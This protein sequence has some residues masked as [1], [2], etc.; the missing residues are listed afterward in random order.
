MKVPKISVIMSV[1][2]GE[3]YL[4]ESVNSILN[5]TF[6]DFEFIIIND[7]S[8]DKTFE[9]LNKITDERVKIILNKKNKGLTASL[10]KCLK[11]ARGKYIARMDAD[12][13]SEPLRLEKEFNFLE[14]NREYGVVGTF[15]KIFN[16]NTGEYI[17]Q[18]KPVKNSEIKEFLK[19]DNCLAHG[20]V[21]IRKEALESSGHYDER[22]LQSQDY[23]LWFRISRNWKLANI[24]EYLYTWRDHCGNIS[25]EKKNE[26]MHY[27]E[28]AK[29]LAKIDEKENDKTK[30]LNPDFSILMAN[31]NNGKYI[32]ES[33]LSVI[34]QTFK[35]WE[36]VIVDDKS[37]DNSIEII[38]SYLKDKR[39]RL[40]KNKINSGYIQSLKKLVYSSRS[41]IFG[42]LDS[43]DVLEKDAIKIMVEN[44]KLNSKCGF[45]YS[46]HILCDEKMD[47]KG[48]GCC[49]NLPINETNLRRNY[50]SAFRTFK[51]TFF[52]KTSGFDNEIIYAEDRD[53]IYKM[54]E[55]TCFK[56]IDKP[57]YKQRILP[58]SQSNN[59][60]KRLTGRISDIEAK[61][62]AY[63][64]RI[65]TDIP[66][67]SCREMSSLCYYGAALSFR[68]IMFYNA[69]IFL[70]RGFRLKFFNP[71]GILIFF[72]TF[73]KDKG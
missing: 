48:M 47:K 22:M 46:Q 34:N 61:Y 19:H 43:D 54:E 52:F 32:K 38:E 65:G 16:Q 37:T 55:V 51:K 1:Y 23:E 14:K 60:K 17:F 25:T 7:G 57:L 40:I 10:N 8:V 63:K 45:I 3:S 31:Y 70:F 72:K 64:R 66:N 73:I 29:I 30:R 56:F 24:P 35:N 69:A 49:S 12:D 11:V 68:N 41:E 18:K 71:G 42:I 13:I 28:Y 67:L 5:Q 33:I 53:I 6:K 27:V 15:I 26:Q 59:P 62:N 4:T 21:L 39:I 58:D 2:N 50:S 44:H 36:L 9:I 20:T